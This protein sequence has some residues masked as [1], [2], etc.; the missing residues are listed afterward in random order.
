MTPLPSPSASTRSI[1]A[2]A[3][4]KTTELCKREF[5]SVTFDL[6][7]FLQRRRLV[8]RGAARKNGRCA[9]YAEDEG[10]FAAAN[11]TRQTEK[12]RWREREG[13]GSRDGGGGGG[14]ENCRDRQLFTFSG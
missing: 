1:G 2:R 5:D 14:G 4:N 6:R 10:C 3:W 9:S 13:E 12:E 11:H 8:S 7:A